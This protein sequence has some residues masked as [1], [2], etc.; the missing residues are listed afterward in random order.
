VAE[1]YNFKKIVN[2]TFLLIISQ[3]VVQSLS[4]LRNAIYGHYLLPADFGV[5]A[6]F[7]M[8]IAAVGM[9]GDMGADKLLIQAK[10]G[11]NTDLQKT[12]HFYNAARGVIGAVILILASPYIIASFSLEGAENAFYIIAL[13]VFIKGFVHLDI[14][15]F[16]RNLNFSPYIITE[17]I[18]QIVAVSLAYPLIIYFHNYYAVTYLIIIHAL[19]YVLVSHLCSK[20]VYKIQFNSTS[21][22]RI[23]CFG[24]PLILNSILMYLILQG[25]K[26]IIGAN[27]DISVLG[28]YSAAFMI[29]MIPALLIIKVLRSVIFPLLTVRQD[30]FRSLTEYYNISTN[31]VFLIVIIF[32]STFIFFGNHIITF[33]FGTQYQGLDKLISILAIMWSIRIIRVPS[34]LIAMSKADTKVALVANLFRSIAVLGVLF[35]AINKYPVEMIAFCGVAGEILASLISIWQIKY[36]FKIKAT[37]FIIRIITLLLFFSVVY[38]FEFDLKIRII[39]FVFLC[40]IVLL[41]KILIVIDSRLHSQCNGVN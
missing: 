2:S 25:D 37:S 39:M 35:F 28:Y 17:I 40:L 20:R 38:F 34:T 23:F 29:T 6:I 4:L 16:Q 5:A 12:I 21:F 26:L 13:V 7:T 11:N 22:N 3:L 8:T 32:S 18:P 30:D 24:W 19:F 1:N 10:D 41:Y 15:R 9:A 33:I 36:K 27:Y 31:I 14:K